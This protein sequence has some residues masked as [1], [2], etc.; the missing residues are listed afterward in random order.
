MFHSI[1]F[2]RIWK[3]FD[4]SRVR[5]KN[6]ESSQQGHKLQI[7]QHDG[8]LQQTKQPLVIFPGGRLLVMRSDDSS[9]LDIIFL[10]LLRNILPSVEI[11]LDIS[12]LSKLFSLEGFMNSGLKT[13]RCHEFMNLFASLAG[14]QVLHTT[15]YTVDS[16]QLTAD[17]RQQSSEIVPLNL[18]LIDRS[19][20]SE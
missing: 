3:Y 17:S 8:A 9:S 15:H 11:S 20:P 14:K 5:T 2:S 6:S 1:E 18:V 7:A 16:S 13:K 4:D 19:L 10:P 12:F